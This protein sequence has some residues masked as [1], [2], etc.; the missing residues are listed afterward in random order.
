[1]TNKLRT[2][3]EEMAKRVGITI[4]EIDFTD[5]NWF[6]TQKWTVRE[7]IDFKNWLI[8]FMENNPEVVD[9]LEAEGIIRRDIKEM[10]IDFVIFYGWDFKKSN[11]N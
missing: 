4:D 1:M 5:E 9:E 2:V 7:E 11:N 3:Y 8:E 10:A 6:T